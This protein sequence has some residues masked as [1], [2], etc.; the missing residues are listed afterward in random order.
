[1]AVTPAMDA[2]KCKLYFQVLLWLGII[3]SWGISLLNGTVKEL[4]LSVWNGHL[5]EERLPLA[6]NY[7]GIPIIDYPL[8]VLVAFFYYGTS[9]H[10]EGYQ[11]FLFDSYGTLTAAFV[12]LYVESLRPNAE[13][14]WMSRP[15]IFGM[16]WQCCGAATALPLYFAIHMQWSSQTKQ[17]TRVARLDQA[18]ALPFAFLLGAVLPTVIGMAPTWLGAHSRPPVTHQM[19]MAAWQPAPIWVAWS[20]YLFS[21]LARGISGGPESKRPG[22][23]AHDEDGNVK[24]IYRWICTSY[25]LAAVLSALAHWY[26]FGRIFTSDNPAVKMSRMY[27]PWLH[28][29]PYGETAADIMVRGPWLFLQYDVIIIGLS[30]LS[31]AFILVRPTPLL[32]NLSGVRLALIMFVASVVISPGAIVSIALLIREYYLPKYDENRTEPAKMRLGNSDRKGYL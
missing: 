19:I 27:I 9:G 18:R 13:P 14:K 1:M 16:L 29:G 15:V 30:S 3:L 20:L 25:L 26:V 22:Y 10:D 5:G 24:K 8:A 4:L 12:W 28:T 23:I 32:K 2:Q 6:T 21:W 31:W 17:V 7:T 11:L